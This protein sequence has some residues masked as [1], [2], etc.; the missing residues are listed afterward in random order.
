MRKKQDPKPTRTC[1]RGVGGLSR[2]TG[3]E[4]KRKPS[5]EWYTTLDI[6]GTHNRKKLICEIIVLQKRRETITVYRNTLVVCP[7]E[8]LI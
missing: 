5:W 4:E 1:V 8:C 3:T 7:Q 2:V 6:P